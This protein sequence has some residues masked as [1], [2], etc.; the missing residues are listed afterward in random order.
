VGD[1]AV[2]WAP[3]EARCP[4]HHLIRGEDP[5]MLY[6][7]HRRVTVASFV[8]NRTWIWWRGILVGAPFPQGGPK[9]P[10]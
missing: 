6:S 7:S 9:N 5:I 2:G 4:L 1:R 10:S 3:S 8:Y